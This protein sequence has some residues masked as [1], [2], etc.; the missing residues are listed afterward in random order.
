MKL[1][2]YLAAAFACGAGVLLCGCTPA[3]SYADYSASSG[4]AL[5]TLD[6]RDAQ[7]VENLDVLCRVWG[8]VKYHHPVFGSEKFNVDY[9][10][11]EL[12]P[13]V[14]HADPATRN[15]VLAAWI[16]G[17]GSFEDGRAGYERTL[18][19]CAD[20]VIPDWTYVT[21]ADLEWTHDTVRLGNPLVERLEKLRYADRRA[22]NR[23]V[24]KMYYPEYDWE[25][26][27]AGFM[28]E[29]PYDDMTDPDCGYRLLA[30]FRFWN[31]VEYFF[32]YKHLTDKP[33][34]DVLPEY[35]GRMIALP[36]GTYNRTMWRMVAEINDSHADYA[37][38]Y[39][40]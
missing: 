2:H 12:L 21:L 18:D 37:A 9:E 5:D 23:Y 15:R 38:L 14:A 27:N 22:G 11:F 32:P 29:E 13:K 8:Y 3:K 33:W 28:G 35:V 4:F 7:V 10:L 1:R 36:D 26:P 16:D 17:L 19:E 6:A 25:T 30:A 34:S 20:C 24:K 39:L 31:M 40:L